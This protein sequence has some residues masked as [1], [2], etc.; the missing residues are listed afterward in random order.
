MRGETDCAGLRRNEKK[1]CSEWFIVPGALDYDRVLGA[2]NIVI[3]LNTLDFFIVPGAL[4][5]Q[6]T[7]DNGSWIL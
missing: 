3:V 2:V 6:S 4:L 7:T 1:L 5:C